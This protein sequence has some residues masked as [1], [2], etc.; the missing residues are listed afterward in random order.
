MTIFSFSSEGFPVPPPLLSFFGGR[1]LNVLNLGKDVIKRRKTGGEERDEN[2]LTAHFCFAAVRAAALNCVTSL[3]KLINLLLKKQK[4]KP[5][6][7]TSPSFNQ[8]QQPI[9]TFHHPKCNNTN[10]I[11]EENS[12]T[13]KI[14]NSLLS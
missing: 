12:W 10:V 14:S 9:T 5:E 11:K 3:T 4:T 7:P 1:I 8:C 6:K 2:T 13:D